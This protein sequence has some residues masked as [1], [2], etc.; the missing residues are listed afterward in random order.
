MTKKRHFKDYTATI[1]LKTHPKDEAWKEL[2]RKLKE[3]R[4]CSEHMMRS[5]LLSDHRQ[6]RRGK[7]RCLRCGYK[8]EHN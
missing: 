7:N 6:Y 1:T 5:M 8:L 4:E 2:N 3:G